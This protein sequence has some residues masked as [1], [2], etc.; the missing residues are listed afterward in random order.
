[1][2]NSKTTFKLKNELPSN[3]IGEEFIVLDSSKK[4]AHELNSL[5][6]F[7]WQKLESE[8]SLDDLKLALL[9]EFDTDIETVTK[10][11]NIF[12]KQLEDKDLLEVNE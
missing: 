7:I 4:K 9:E 11:V 10:D 1:M 2:W 8:R 3:E 12:L 5:G 6:K